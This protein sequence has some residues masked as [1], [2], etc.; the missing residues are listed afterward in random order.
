[1]AKDRAKT[2]DGNLISQFMSTIQHPSQWLDSKVTSSIREFAVEAE[3]L[4]DLTASQLKI[5][6]DNKWFRMFVP[7][8]H[9]GLG[10]SLPE[11]LRI[12]EGLSWADGST[13]WVVTLCSGAGW[14]VGFLD[15][16]ITGT[17]IN[18]DQFCIA[19]SGASTGTADMND[20]GYLIS[21][22]WKYASGSLHATAFTVNCMITSNGKQ[23]YNEDGSPRIQPFI[24]KPDEV[25]VR[26]TWNSMGMVATASHSFD[27]ESLQV[28]SQRRFIIEPS[29]AVLPDIVY[30]Y[31]FLQLAETTLAVNL[32]GLASRFIDLC[33]ST[34]ARQTL[35][36]YRRALFNTV[37]MS[38]QMLAD[39]SSISETVLLD[40]SKVSHD[41]VRISRDIINWLNPLQGLKAADKTTEINR[42]WRNFHTAA[43]HSL[44]KKIHLG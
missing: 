34:Y 29:R 6:H 27:I 36:S 19:G 2:I 41:L 25:T 20:S 44:F 40:V 18:D 30:Q 37:D 13:A 14:F 42:V 16:S 38:W 26:R 43:Q 22:S 35:D 23:L 17:L 31:P 4:Q 28:P 21:G 5:I 15:P 3:M 39:K 24:L 33:E 11:V 1:L 8:K 12:E 32:S 10:L 9:G 7:Q